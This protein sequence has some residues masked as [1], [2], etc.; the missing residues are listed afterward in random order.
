MNWQNIIIPGIVIGVFGAFFAFVLAIVAKKFAVKHDPKVE[1]LT[2]ILPG[3]N[4]GG[5]G[6]PNCL[7]YAEVLSRDSEVVVTLCKPGG[8]EVAEKLGAA[9][10][11]EVAA[12]EKQVAKLLC[13]G[14]K[15]RAQD[16]F[17][18]SG[19]SLCRAADLVHNG[20]KKCKQGCLGFGDC[21]RVCQFDAI[22]MSENNLPIIDRDKCVACGA[23]VNA[24]P[25]GLLQIVPES[26]RVFVEC[27]NTDKGA[28]TTKACEVGC[29]GCGLCVKECPFDAIHVVNNVA[30]IDYE[31]CKQCGKCVRVCPRNIILQLPR[32][33]KKQT[34]TM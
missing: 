4:C 16:E 31:K 21:F 15:H 18:Y 24:C 32:V 30:V 13:R 7:S 33:V 29:I 14:G 11:R 17:R 22:E 1:E 26:A 20:Y 2:E 10:G 9:L 28:K 23:C 12:S 25:R 5:C 6:F 27:I 8:A 34:V 19:I 3:L